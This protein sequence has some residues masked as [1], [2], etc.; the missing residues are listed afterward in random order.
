MPWEG[1]WMSI[2]V[3]LPAGG[4]IAGEFAEET[5]VSVKALVRIDGC[6]VL[7]RTIAALRATGLVN[8]TIVI[9]PQ[10]IAD[11]PVAKCADAV[12]PEGGDSGPANIL[13]GLKWLRESDGSHA[14]RVLIMTT[15]LPF[16]TSRAI[17]DFIDRSPANA[18]LTAPLVSEYAF[19]Q[20]FPGSENE[21]VKLADGRWTMGCGFLVDPRSVEANNDHIE[22]AFQARKSQIGMAKL[23]GMGFILRFLSGRL[24]V[25]DI[26]RQ[27]S[28]MLGCACVAVPDSPAELAFDLD[29][30]GEYRYAISHCS[31]TEATPD[32]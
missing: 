12:L 2:D 4:R 18:E 14:D 30:I 9:G 11:H 29:H 32:V 16:L 31:S 23:L 27:C 3:V 10:E 6:T 5:G 26:E 21:Y 8:R 22:A 28:K 20:R 17:C 1:L 24:T 15:D 7:E 19:E 25:P 13:A